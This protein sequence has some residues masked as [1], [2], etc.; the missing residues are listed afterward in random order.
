MGHVG[1]FFGTKVMLWLT[2]GPGAVYSP[3]ASVCVKK[4]WVSLIPSVPNGVCVHVAFL[5]PSA[6][7][8]WGQ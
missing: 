6:I 4:T 8:S 2:G 1:D 3:G 7:A 5:K